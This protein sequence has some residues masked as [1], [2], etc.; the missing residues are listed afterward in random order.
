MTRDE[1]LRRVQDEEKRYQI[2]KD[3]ADN[4]TISYNTSEVIM[5]RLMQTTNAKER[6]YAQSVSFFS[7]NDSVLTAL[8]ASFTGLFGLHEL[9]K[10]SNDE[11]RRLEMIEVLVRARRQGAGS[12]HPRRVWSDHPGRAVKSLSTRHE[13]PGASFG[14]I[15]E[16]RKLSTKI[17]TKSATPLRTATAASQV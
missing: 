5:A 15:D 14:I 1:H 6:V 13:L 7:T 3:L 4:L 17:R 16:M 11:G 12:G 9:T 8:K 10:R 2:A